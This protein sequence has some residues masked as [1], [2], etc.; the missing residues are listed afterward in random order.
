MGKGDIDAKFEKLEK[1][2][3]LKTKQD[4]ENEFLYG[5]GGA[6][7]AQASGWQKSGPVRKC[8]AKYEH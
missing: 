5:I 2:S 3:K 4:L 7:M 8:E 6:M 1:Q